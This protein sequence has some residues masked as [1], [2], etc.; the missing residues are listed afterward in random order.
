MPC[1]KSVAYDE[2]LLL[3]H[4]AT[5]LCYNSDPSSNHEPSICDAPCFTKGLMAI[6]LW[7]KTDP[8]I[9]DGFDARE[10]SKRLSDYMFYLLYEQQGMMSEVSGISKLRFKDTSSES[11]RFFSEYGGQDLGQGCKNILEVNTSVK[12]VHVKGGS[13]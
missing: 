1:V 7:N 13:I 4:I 9:C 8:H 5:E 10:F 3:W 12:P 11:S 6:K 2:S